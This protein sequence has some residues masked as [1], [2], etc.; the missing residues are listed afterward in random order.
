ML[1]S[2]FHSVQFHVMFAGVSLDQKDLIAIARLRSGLCQLAIP[3]CCVFW[4]EEDE[5]YDSDGE[6]LYDVQY[7]VGTTVT[8]KVIRKTCQY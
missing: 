3:L 5:E 8:N 2:S 4:N 1:T 6:A 7:Q